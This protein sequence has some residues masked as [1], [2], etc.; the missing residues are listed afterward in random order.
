MEYNAACAD[1]WSKQNKNP[2]ITI[3]S[4]DQA[5]TQ[6]LDKVLSASGRD[7]DFI[8]DDGGHNMV[9]QFVSFKHLFPAKT[10]GFI[11]SRTLRLAS[12]RNMAVLTRR[13]A[14]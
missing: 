11:S 7:L 6:D 9:Q 2:R 14:R 8:I 5:K 3:I 1:K 4:G 10:A 12:W 13:R